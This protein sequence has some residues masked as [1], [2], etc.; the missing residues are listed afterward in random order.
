MSPE[1]QEQ[2]QHEKVLGA[3]DSNAPVAWE[4]PDFSFATLK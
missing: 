4:S 3:D 1:Q 2:Q